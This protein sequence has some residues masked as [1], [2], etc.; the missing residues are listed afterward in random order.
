LRIAKVKY[1]DTDNFL[2][3]LARVGQLLVGQL[4]V[5]GFGGF[6]ADPGLSL[7]II[8]DASQCLSDAALAFGC[9]GGFGLGFLFGQDLGGVDRGIQRGRD[10][11][12]VLLAGECAQALGIAGRD[13]DAVVLALCRALQSGQDRFNDGEQAILDR[14]VTQALDIN[15]V[16]PAQG[17]AQ[18]SAVSCRLG[19]TSGLSSGLVSTL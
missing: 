1:K 7:D 17:A 12:R 11:P 13:R 8:G 16:D 15:G 3:H 14:L 18:F 19:A 5:Q 2:Q 4:Q 10:V 9:S 6:A